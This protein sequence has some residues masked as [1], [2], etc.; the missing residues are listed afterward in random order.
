MCVVINITM[1]VLLSRM[2]GNVIKRQ[3]QIDNILNRLAD[4]TY[5]IFSTQITTSGELE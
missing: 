3:N 5:V 4:C 2:V 1:L